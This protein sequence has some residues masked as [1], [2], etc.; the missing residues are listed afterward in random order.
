MNAISMHFCYHRI[1]LRF[2]FQSSYLFQLCFNRSSPF[3]VQFYTVHGN[4]VKVPYFLSDTTCL[5][6]SRRQFLNNL[7]KLLAIVLGKHIK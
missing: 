6:L 2:I 4:V 7:M 5:V 1:N 3:T